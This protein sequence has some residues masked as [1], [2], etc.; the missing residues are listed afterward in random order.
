MLEL[1]LTFY[2]LDEMRNKYLKIPA[3]QGTQSNLDSNEDCQHYIVCVVL[4][5]VLKILCSPIF[6]VFPPNLPRKKPFPHFR[7]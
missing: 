1:N 3:P 6:G 5:A 7:S 4:V 2:C